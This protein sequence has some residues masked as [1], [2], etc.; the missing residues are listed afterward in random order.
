MKSELK[1]LVELAKRGA[2]HNVVKITTSKLGEIMGVSQ[3]TASRIL[4]R[5]EREDLIVREMG[6]KGTRISLSEKGRLRLESLYLTLERIFGEAEEG[7]EGSL[8]SGAGEGG[9]YVSRNGYLKQFSEKL[10]FKPYPGTLNLLLRKRDYLKARELMKSYPKIEIKGFS[11]KDRSFGDVLCYKVLIEDIE[12][13]LV[14]PLRTHH[15]KNVV[16]IISKWY[17]R[18]KLRLKDGDLVKIRML[19]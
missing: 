14:L 5:L 2:F 9:Y 17:L 13:A 6:L 8:I 15:S 12:G 3:Q 10:G 1:V 11:D 16:E 18:E 19:S 4:L 7:F